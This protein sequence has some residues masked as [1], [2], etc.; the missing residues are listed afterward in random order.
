MNR[1]QIRY[2]RLAAILFAAFLLLLVLVKVVDVRPIGANGSSVGLAGL[3]GIFQHDFVPFWYTL[4]EI[5]GGIAILLCAVFGVL[6]LR[7]LIHRRKILSVNHSIILL[8]CFYLLVIFLYVFFEHVVINMRPVLLP[9]ATELE[10]SFPS[11][12]TLLSIFAFG[13]AIVM[14]RG[15]LLADQKLRKIFTIVCVALLAI[16]V[17]GRLFSGAHWFTDIF[18]SVLLGGSLVCLFY[19]LVYRLLSKEDWRN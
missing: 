6:G 1:T 16:T 10:A 18:A 14:L 19:A 11:S 3:N 5:T 4:T 2:F 17:L 8:G 12:H 7:Q 13:S 9:G 15:S